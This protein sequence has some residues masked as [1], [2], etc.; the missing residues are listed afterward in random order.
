[1][2][3][4]SMAGKGLGRERIDTAIES[5]NTTRKLTHIVFVSPASFGVGD[6]GEPFELLGTSASWPNCAGVNARRSIAPPVFPTATRS[7]AM[8]PALCFTA[9]PTLRLT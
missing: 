7:F 2:L 1:V 5:C 9:R 8:P 4:L 6:I 3:Q